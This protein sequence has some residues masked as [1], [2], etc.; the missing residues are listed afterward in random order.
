M[1]PRPSYQTYAAFCE[2]FDEDANV[3]LP[4][5]R[6]VAN[7][8]VK[9]SRP[10][11]APSGPSVD[12]ASDSGYSSRTAITVDSGDSF[13][14]GTSPTRDIARFRDRVEGKE[15]DRSGNK[16]REKKEGKENNK[17]PPPPLPPIK[18]MPVASARSSSRPPSLQKGP[19]KPGKRDSGGAR[20]HPGTC[21]DCD[22]WGLHQA[23]LAGNVDLRTMESANYF[24]PHPPH[25]Y[26]VPPSP[27]TPRYPP[28]INQEMHPATPIIPQP[29]PH[30][31]NSYHTQNRPVS[32]HSG[33]VPDMNMMYMS[34]GHP[35]AYGHGPPLSASAYSNSFY[36]SS[37][38]MGGEVTVHQSPTPSYEVAPRSS[39]ERPRER[40]RN[41]SASRPSTEKPSGRRP[42]V[43]KRPVV[44]YHNSPSTQFE[45]E[46]YE[47]RPPPERRA[48][49]QSRSYDPDE[50]YYRMAPPPN[51][52]VKYKQPTQVIPVNK[53]PPTRKAS[54]TSSAP[55]IHRTEPYDMSDMR[56]ALP[57]RMDV[58]FA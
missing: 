13:A 9:R 8:S 38:Y 10:E 41:K 6:K 57:P 50:D 47:P 52:P 54:T 51:P 3:V 49:R 1:S 11:L 37:P 12:G 19:S 56:A 42:S 27:Q 16:T 40:P 25:G 46:E 48:R 44:E 21:W 22:Q 34:M 55:T 7:V 32:F 26:E 36:P 28:S 18:T 58:T 4:G 30:R 35:S 14:S 31:S 39:Y 5:T 15:K 20:H 43:Y 29:R 23:A 33:T 24:Q 53:R 45:P 2:E 17:S